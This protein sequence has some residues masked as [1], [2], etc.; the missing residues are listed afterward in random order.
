MKTI[1]P[2][3]VPEVDAD[4]FTCGVNYGVRPFEGVCF[5]CDSVTNHKF[6]NTWRC[7]NCLERMQHVERARVKSVASQAEWLRSLSVEEREKW[8]KRCR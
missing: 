6:R 4:L 5:R 8:H 3:T 7:S 1:P 2:Y